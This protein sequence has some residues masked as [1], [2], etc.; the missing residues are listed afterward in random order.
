MTQ[1][2]E[3][4]VLDNHK[5]TRPYLHAIGVGVVGLPMSVMMIGSLLTS[6]ASAQPNYIDVIDF[7]GDYVLNDI[8]FDQ[9]SAQSDR[10][11]NLTPISMDELSELRSAGVDPSWIADRFEL[12]DFHPSDVRL[13]QGDHPVSVESWANQHTA[14]NG[15]D[16]GDSIN[17]SVGRTTEL[18]DGNISGSQG[19]L[20]QGNEHLPSLAQAEGE[21]DM[22]DIALEWRAVDAGPVS[23]SVISGLKA[24]EANIGKPISKGGLSTTETVHRFTAMPMIGSSVR[25]E[26]NPDISFSSSALTHPTDTGNSLI[27]FNASTDLRL[28]QNMDFS[29]GYRIIRSSFE[30][31]SVDTDVSQEGLFARL[32]ISF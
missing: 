6:A 24:I 3:M 26:I 23:F 9:R 27:D 11:T 25:W 18:R 5:T 12:P 1:F 4:T 13:T 14:G 21:Y 22:Y 2:N 8:Y 30:V 16:L 28:T 31:G 20:D 10:P 19:S 15:V 17:F 7:N 32:Q 29:A